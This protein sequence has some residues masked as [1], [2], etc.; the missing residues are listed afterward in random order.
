MGLMDFLNG[1]SELKHKRAVT[2]NIQ[3][4]SEAKVRHT[5]AETLAH[6][7]ATELEKRKL[8]HLI[9][10]DHMKMIHERAKLNAQ[11]ALLNHSARTGADIEFHGVRITHRRPPVTVTQEQPVLAGQ[12]IVQPTQEYAISQLQ[13][14]RM[15]VC[16]GTSKETGKPFTRD[17]LGGTH[18]MI[19]GGSGFGKSCYAASLLDQVT[20]TN[21]RDHL[22]IALLDLEHKTSRLFEDLPHVVQYQTGRR[23]IDGVAQNAEEVA[24]HLGYLHRVLDRRAQMSEYDLQRSHVFLIYVEEFLALQYEVDPDLKDAM[25][26]DFSTLALR[27]R[28][29]KMFLLCCTQASYATKALRDAKP[30]FNVRA[31]FLVN[32]AV[33]R[34]AGFTATPLLNRNFA[35]KQ[36]GQ[37]VLETTGC[38]DI[39]LAPI[40]D[41]SRKVLQKERSRGVQG[42]FNQP[43]SAFNTRLLN[44]PERATEERSSDSERR[45]EVLKLDEMGWSKQEIVEKLWN[46]SKGGGAQWQIGSRAYD[47]IMQAA[48]RSRQ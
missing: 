30:Q 48:G 22:Q 35:D 4:E 17:L 6:L 2:R 40:F 25:L 5:D 47:S 27:G 29:Y 14:N 37:L 20:A 41:V 9:E 21:D 28:K 26:A 16:L 24:E 13:E 1:H 10:Q 11:I 18:Y 3:A 15:Q 43:E 39:M 34:S 12:T 33:A 46:C 23:R 44:G 7:A 19:I 42:A 38:T 32:P 8:N 31:S 45:L 36:P